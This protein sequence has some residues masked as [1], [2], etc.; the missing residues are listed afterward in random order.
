MD[1][2][3]WMALPALCIALAMLFL[4]I[5]LLRLARSGNQWQGAVRPSRHNYLASLRGHTLLRSVLDEIERFN[6]YQVGVSGHSTAGLRDIV[7]IV[8]EERTTSLAEISFEYRSGMA[9]SIDFK[10]L[11]PEHAVRLV[12]F[13]SGLASASNGWIFRAADHVI[14]LVPPATS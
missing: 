7:R 6:A 12:D 14:I 1:E 3:I 9:V 5:A 8:P 11:T 2:D 10:A 4:A 13:C